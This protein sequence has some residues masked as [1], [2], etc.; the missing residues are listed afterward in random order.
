MESPEW[1]GITFRS[2][3][4]LRWFIG[5]MLIFFFST[6]FLLSG[7]CF[8]RDRLSFIKKFNGMWWALSF[9]YIS[10][11]L[12]AVFCT[13]MWGNGSVVSKDCIWF[14]GIMAL[15]YYLIYRIAGRYLQ[16]ALV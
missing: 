11:A 6:A 7:L 8:T 12:M 5:S 14:N 3:S 16:K 4:H 10:M 13:L 9:S 2:V 15:I 1:L